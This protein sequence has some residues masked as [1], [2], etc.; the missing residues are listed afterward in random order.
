MKK[1]AFVVL[2]LAAWGVHAAEPYRMG[3]IM[4]L[5]PDSVLQKRVPSVQSLSDYIGALQV[6]AQGALDGKSGSPSSGQLVVAVRPGGQ[7]KAW[8]DFRPA[9]QPDVAQTLLKTVEAVP[10]FEAKEGV[11]VFSLNIALWGA[12]PGLALPPSPPEWREAMKSQK[13]PEEI[14]HLVERVWVGGPGT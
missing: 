9:L 10:P 5:Q 13:G 6:A 4:L 8:L 1:I 2:L 14:G 11:V 3:G 7:S 12:T